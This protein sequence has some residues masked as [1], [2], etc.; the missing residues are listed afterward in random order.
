MPAWVWPSPCCCSARQPKLQGP[1]QLSKPIFHYSYKQAR[2]TQNYLNYRRRQYQ[3][4]ERRELAALR[5]NHREQ[6]RYFNK[7]HQRKGMSCNR[8][9]C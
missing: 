8:E 2:F 1:I 6:Q 7:H 3:R 9:N 5:R 4:Q